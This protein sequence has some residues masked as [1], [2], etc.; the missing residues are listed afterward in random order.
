MHR[1]SLWFASYPR[2]AQPLHFCFLAVLLWL[3]HGLAIELPLSNI[4]LSFY[5]GDLWGKM[6]MR[7]A[8][9]FETTPYYASRVSSEFMRVLFFFVR[10]APRHWASHVIGPWWQR[11]ILDLGFSA[12]W[13]CRRRDETVPLKLGAGAISIHWQQ[14]LLG[15][16]IKDA[17]VP[18]I[19]HHSARPLDC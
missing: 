13:N 15:L 1:A 19:A 4:K 8:I 14:E 7:E 6:M 17:F 10:L 3:E 2:F 9:G 16:V 11:D 12:A 5:S 18:I